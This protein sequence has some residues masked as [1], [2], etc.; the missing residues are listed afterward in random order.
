MRIPSLYSFLSRIS[1]EHVSKT[2][3]ECRSE[4]ISEG[5]EGGE[6]EGVRE[7]ERMLSGWERN[8]EESLMGVAGNWL[9]TGWEGSGVCQRRL[10]LMIGWGGH[11]MIKRKGGTIGGVWPIEE[12]NNEP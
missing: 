11:E 3:K 7:P 10:H 9:G 2:K 6:K 5:E 1:W 12:R 8:L 4:G